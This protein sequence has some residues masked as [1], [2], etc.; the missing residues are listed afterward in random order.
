MDGL[1]AAILSVKLKYI[2]QWND[3]RLQNA[4]RYNELFAS[5]EDIIAPSIHPDVKHIFHLY[6]IRT[7][8]REKL[9]AHL[10][11]SGIETAI[12]YPSALPFLKAYE[13]LGHRPEDFPV[14]Y[15]HSS[16]I[17]SLPMYPELSEE[18]QAKVARQSIIALREQVS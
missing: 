12:H 5:V 17:L 8:Q 14:A 4:L 9:Q 18:M 1:Q 11:R 6:V 2:E 10:Q 15:Q 7:E 3:K 16:Q 13:Y